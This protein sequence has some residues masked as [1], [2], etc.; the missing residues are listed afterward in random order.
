[1]KIAGR[2]LVGLGLIAVFAAGVATGRLAEFGEKVEPRE[3]REIREGRQ[4]YTNPLLECELAEE[5]LYTFLRP[6][7][8]Q[9]EKLIAALERGQQVGSIAVYFRDLNSGPWIGHDEKKH[10]IPAS[11]AK[12]PVVIACFR[13]TEIDPGFLLRKVVFEGI[14]EERD[15]GFL[16]PESN[17]ERG[18]SYSV[19]ELIL[20]VAKYSDNTAARLLAQA[21]PPVLL[22]AVYFDLGVDPERLKNKDFSLSPKEYSAFFRVLYNASYL[23]K[24]YS[25]QA[26]EYFDRS[27]FE[28]G[29]VAGVPEGTAVSHKF[30]V[31]ED[32]SPGGQ[33]SLQLHDCGIIYHPQHPYLLCVM[34]AGKNYVDMTKAIAAVSRFTYQQV[35]RDPR[36]PSDSLTDEPDAALEFRPQ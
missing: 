36:R 19:D 31:W 16:N 2:S 3:D 9:L 1:M 5:R 7:G 30:G 22:Q 15:P 25:E 24:R 18:R 28:L 33:L 6:F 21:V 20:R 13:Q 34:T 10:Y 12:L 8:G 14:A 29:L 23:S 35:D 32:S 26:L 4:G 27:T 17:M 11:L